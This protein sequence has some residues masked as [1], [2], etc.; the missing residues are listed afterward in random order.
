MMLPEYARSI[1]EFVADDDGLSVVE[2][3]VGAALLALAIGI[4]FAEYDTK[5]ISKI[6]AALS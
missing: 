3:V 5:L 4:L 6:E 1:V 2:Y